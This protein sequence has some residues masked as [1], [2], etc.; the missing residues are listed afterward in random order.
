[1]KDRRTTIFQRKGE[2]QE[3]TCILTIQTYQENL[4]KKKKFQSPIV[5]CTLN[6][7]L[8]QSV[9]VSNLTSQ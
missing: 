8:S 4:K 1:M 9:H 2:R 3:I 5:P 6:D 7:A